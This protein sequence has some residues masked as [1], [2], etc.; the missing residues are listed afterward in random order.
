MI[1]P[2]I[3]LIV[4]A[5]DETSP[6]HKRSREWWETLIGGD[7]IIGLPWAVV[8]G[9]LRLVTHPRVFATPVTIEVALTRVDSWIRRRNIVMIDPG[10]R[11]WELLSEMLGQVRLGGKLVNDA[12]I[13]A[14]AL[15]Y[16]AE[17]YTND[18]DFERFSGLL[19]RNPLAKN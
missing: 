13:A 10:S 17:L 19:L 9:F 2:D 12:H 15:A 11:H 14:L 16:R 4:Y 3:N 18:R 1:I 6:F 5:Y 8:V 7:E